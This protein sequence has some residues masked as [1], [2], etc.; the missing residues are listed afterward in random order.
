MKPNTMNVVTRIAPSPTGE[1]HIGTVRTALFN[2]LFAR[3]YGGTFFVRIED[4]DKERNKAEWID[5]IWNDFKWC[6]LD[7]DQRYIQ[8]EHVERH[9]ELLQ[10]L[11]A[12]NKAYV[13]QEEAKDGSGRMVEVVRLRNAGT[14]VTFNDLVRGE[15]T[16]DTS[17]LGDFV[18]A[19]S[20]EDPL[21][22]FAVVVD[23][24]EAGVT[25]VIRAEEHISNTPR[26]ILIQEALGFPR[27]QY[28][29][30]PLILAPDKSKLSKRKHS[31]SVSM[32]RERGFLP[33]ALLN[34]L[35]LLGWNPGTD[36]EM[37]TL[38]QLVERFS[39]D[40]VQKHGAVFDEKKLRWFNKEY[41]ATL[42]EETFEEKIA[43]YFSQETLETLQTTGRFKKMIPELRQRVEVFSDIPEMEREGEFNYFIERPVYAKEA[44]LWHKDPDP[45]A[46]H[47]HLSVI[48]DALDT[49]DENDWNY[50]A[51]KWCL[52]EYA[53]EK[54]KGNVLWPLRYALSGRDKSP[55]PFSL[56]DILG[57]DE[58][59]AR[60][61]KAMDIL[62]GSD[63]PD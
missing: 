36:E 44:L 63:T 59:R 15:V 23:D 33:E 27:P 37:F 55:D 34:Y 39:L 14:S 13:S 41:L 5:A 52:W 47:G 25:H 56:A 54:G 49:I 24:H 42:D 10:T 18:I 26:Q 9:K 61:K 6:G 53:E 31:A 57:K 20:L 40:Q 8:S 28:A 16:F 3:H 58:T 32:Y 45:Q 46:T 30:I 1:M 11:V 7:I 12:N 22:H 29:H 60:I 17:E 2:Y 35:A 19:R 43:P 21:Y 48:F 62:S 4:T 51:V 38:E 50:N